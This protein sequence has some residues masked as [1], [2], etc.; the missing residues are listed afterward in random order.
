MRFFVTV[1]ALFALLAPQA[2]QAKG[3]RVDTFA[4]RAA[5]THGIAGDERYVFITEPGVGVAPSGARVVV[6]DRFSGGE[7][8]TLPAP[9]GG[10][11]LP[12]TLRVPRTGHLVVLD[13]GGF[14]PVGPP[15]VYDYAY[16]AQHGFAAELTRTTNF[17]GNPLGFAE[18]VEVLPNGEYVVSESVF[19]GLWLIGR[20]GAIRRGLVPDDGAAPLPKLGSCQFSGPGAVG[21][22]PF[23]APGAFAPGAGSLA[24]RGKDLYVSSTCEGGVQRVPIRVLLDSG[25]PAAERAL[26]IVTVTPRQHPLE[27][28]KG[29]TFNRWDPSD[30]WIYAGDPFQLT[31]IRI[32]SRTGRREVL[33]NDRR[34]FNFTVSTGFLPPV[35]RGKPN[36][37][38]TA[39]DQEYRWSATNAALGGTDRFEP[40]FILAEYSPT[41]Q[42][43]R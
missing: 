35:R 12:F 42:G 27:S 18:D 39:S 33:S 31:L 4:E 16:R 19:G 23:E 28:L 26:Q 43:R 20:D 40:P 37:L 30:P 6:L 17:V 1:L 25:R 34:R 22:L 38:V 9:E 29:I 10:F 32:N 41:K 5:L 14:P 24:V 2:A 15:V 21:D 36:P 8:A 7:V 3:G 13:S 11:K